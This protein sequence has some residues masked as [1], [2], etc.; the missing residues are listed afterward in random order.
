MT[1]GAE[2]VNTAFMTT[3]E[4][5]ATLSVRVGA[6]I[7]AN[8]ARLGLSQAELAEQLGE[9]HWWLSDRE[10]GRVPINLD[11][12]QRIADALDQVAHQRGGARVRLS[13]LMPADTI[14]PEAYLVVA[15]QPPARALSRERDAPDG[16]AAAA[17]TTSPR[18]RPRTRAVRVA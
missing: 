5:P 4:R 16:R 8:R 2:P 13:D 3:P 11:E 18:L 1:L 10:R 17:D 14:D 9:A 6:E 7:R 12:L 15:A